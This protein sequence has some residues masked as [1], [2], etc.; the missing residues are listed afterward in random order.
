MNKLFLFAAT[1][2]V[3]MLIQQ[4]TVECKLNS[5]KAAKYIDL[6]CN[7]I[8][9]FG[10]T[11]RVY[12]R[13][14]VTGPIG[15]FNM[16]PVSGTALQVKLYDHV[17][18]TIKTYNNV[19]V[20]GDGLNGVGCD[21]TGQYCNLNFYGGVATGAGLVDMNTY[22][23]ITSQVGGLQSAVNSQSGI[24]YQTDCTPSV[25]KLT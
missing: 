15:Q 21:A 8:N 18:N 13:L 22:F 24:H 9:P 25:L 19:K 17:G 7:S 6:K 3:F 10:Y 4:F 5:A 11:A 1:F 14:S 23:K 20:K 2:L 12:G 16:Y